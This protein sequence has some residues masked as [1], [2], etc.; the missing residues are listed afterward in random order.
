MVPIQLPMVITGKV[1]K[2]EQEEILVKKRNK[3]RI[4][5]S[6]DEED[7]KPKCDAKESELNFADLMD[8]NRSELL[9]FQMPDQLPNPGGKK[10]NLA[11]LDEGFLGKIQLRKSGKVQFWINNVLF[12]V[13]IGTQVGFLQELF[14]VETDP[15][16]RNL[17]NLG[18]VRNRVVVMPAWD[19][20]LS[21]ANVK[22]NSSDSSSDEGEK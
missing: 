2:E 9:F 12:D 21:A 4:L 11:D 10:S 18:R 1:F 15:E 13:D 16:N 20:L 6:D 14:S 5:D 3:N 17:T 19:E 8:G 7:E 22:E